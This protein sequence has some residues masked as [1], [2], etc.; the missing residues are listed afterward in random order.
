MALD[1]NNKREAMLADSCYQDLLAEYGTFY[2]RFMFESFNKDM[3]GQELLLVNHIVDG[4]NAKTCVPVEVGF[5][6]WYELQSMLLVTHLVLNPGCRIVV[7]TAGVDSD[8]AIDEQMKR[9]Y[10]QC[11]DLIIKHPWLELYISATQNGFNIDNGSSIVFKKADPGR[12]V[13]LAGEYSDKMLTVLNNIDCLSAAAWKVVM[14]AQTGLD[15]RVVAGGRADCGDTLAQRWGAN[16]IKTD[17]NIA[18]L[19][20][21]QEA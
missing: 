20:I 17:W 21:A 6:D 11:T 2:H 3:T 9:I 1:V 19:E 5:T 13:K 15:N 10:K 16:A 14:C 4:V 12:E 7:I 8:Q 18:P